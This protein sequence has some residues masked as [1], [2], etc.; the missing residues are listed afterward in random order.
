MSSTAPTPPILEKVIMVE[1]AD[2]GPK[3]KAK[4]I[5]TEAQLEALKLGRAKLAEKRR[6]L[7]EEKE[8]EQGQS[9]TNQQVT[10]TQ[11]LV[12]QPSTEEPQENDDDNFPT[13][14]TIV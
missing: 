11:Q 3:V 4:R 10:E 12:E 2:E 8:K 7:A 14:C 1:A 13:Y 9:T 5:L 6:L